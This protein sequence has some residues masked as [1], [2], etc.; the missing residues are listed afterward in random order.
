M[1]ATEPLPDLDIL[2]F[3][4][5]KALVIQKHA[6]VTEQQAEIVTH[7]NEIES[8]NLLIAKLKRMHFGPRS[9]K[10][11][12]QI[13]QLQLRLEDLEINRAATE[14]QAESIPAA[15]EQQPATT[16]A[17]R[18]RKILAPEL[19]REIQILEP[20]QSACP[21]CGGSLGRLGGD[22]SEMLEYVPSHL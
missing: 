3:V 6:I 14:P 9:E 13:E 21:D 17:K 10:L 22:V 20:E 2:D 7:K 16:A 11:G 12:Q 4:A 1:I 15:A 5:L 8:L 18:K 19:P